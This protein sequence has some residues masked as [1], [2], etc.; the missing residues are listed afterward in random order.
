MTSTLQQGVARKAGIYVMLLVYCQTRFLQLQGWN[1][2][3]I[4]QNCATAWALTLSRCIPEVRKGMGGCC[5]Q[6]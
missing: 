2:P 5:C 4:P 3:S 6:H 1:C